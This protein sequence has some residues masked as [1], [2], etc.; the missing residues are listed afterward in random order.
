[1]TES[2]A[3]TL[4]QLETALV[5]ENWPL[6]DE[7]LEELLKFV[8]QRGHGELAE[9]TENVATR[10]A[11]LISDYLVRRPD[12]PW[13]PLIVLT[14]HG[15]QFRQIYG[16]S[17]FGSMVHLQP[18]LGRVGPDQRYRFKDERAIARFAIAITLGTLNEPRM[19]LLK[20]HLAPGYLSKLLI[21]MLGD[22]C[23]FDETSEIWRNRFLEQPDDL[24]VDKPDHVDL[25]L[26]SALWM[27]CSYASAPGKHQVKRALNRTYRNWVARFDPPFPDFEMPP[28]RS[29]PLLLVTMEHLSPSH[30]MY[31]SYGRSIMALSEVF[32]LVYAGPTRQIPEELAPLLTQ[33]FTAPTT[34]EG[35][36][37]FLRELAALRPDVVYFPSVGMAPWNTIL[38]TQRI[39]PLQV[40]SQGHPATTMLDTIDFVLLPDETGVD[41]ACYTE[42]LVFHRPEA[43]YVPPGSASC[44]RQPP[45]DGDTTRRVAIP[46]RLF[47]LSARFIACCEQINRRA[48]VPFEFHFFPNE[49]AVAL[50]HLENSLAGRIPAVVHQAAT[51]QDYA[52][53]IA[54]CDVHLSS[55]PFGATNSLVDSLMQGL[56]PVSL[57]GPEIHSSVDGLLIRRME[58]PDWLVCE[59]EE[60]YIACA[61]RLLE[62]DDERERLSRQIVECG[63][64]QDRL[65]ADSGLPRETLEIIDWLHRNREQILADGRQCWYPR[66]RDDFP[67]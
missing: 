22:V 53:N 23:M 11:A 19:Q 54:A 58:L 12:M 43:R 47:K 31:R 6:I 17:G 13:K 41:P 27:H 18:I 21:S 60:E 42:R 32:D 24:V 46:A 26:A 56:V 29:R 2:Q 35:Y 34:F 33:T 37:D 14:L 61:V 39:A 5:R 55:F 38:A 40:A 36:P 20:Q 49:G 4:E 51:Y 45:I 16:A 7:A 25:Q 10:I 48:R 44:M 67:A 1:M 3:P 28:P 30:A 52:A 8:K 59:T 62:N 64:V 15:T 50:K 66:D 9:K 57:K 65:M 63:L